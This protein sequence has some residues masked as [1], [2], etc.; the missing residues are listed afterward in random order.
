MNDLMCATPRPIGVS[1]R[2]RL[3]LLAPLVL[4]TPRLVAATGAGVPTPPQMLGPYYP[5]RPDSTAGSD[6]TTVDGIGRARGA[7]LAIVGRVLDTAGAPQ[8]GVLVEI[9]QTNAF[10]RYHHPHDDSPQPLDANFRGYGRAVTDAS[11]SYRFA[12]IFPVAYPGRTPHVH[13]RLSRGSREL[14][15]TQMYLPD[16]AAANA[17]DGLFRGLDSASR[18]RLLGVPE[19]GIASTLRFDIV[20][21]AG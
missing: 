5:L 14:L 10:G 13:F 15:V 17:R 21:G 20:L 7:P 16:A 8:P 2:R 3:A 9:W 1:R 11:G 19:A 6:L 4:L 12:T 18:R